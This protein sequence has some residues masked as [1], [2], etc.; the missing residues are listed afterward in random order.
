MSLRSPLGTA[1]GLGSAKD[2]L[3][4]WWAQRVT[5]I[6]LIPLTV[7]F[8]F[9]VALL[10]MSD[11]KTVIDC[12]GSPWS[13]A[14]IVS[15]IVAAFYHAALGMQVIYEDYISNK[16]IRIGAI[17]TTNLMLF[18]LGTAAII[19]VLRIALGG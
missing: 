4:H 11:Y 6:A 10:S 3:H 12:I 2:G 19:A 15:L 13:S 16:A 8:A 14:L 1:K 5:A 9:Q 18:L 7:L 17:M